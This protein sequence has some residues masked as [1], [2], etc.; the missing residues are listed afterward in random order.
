MGLRA[1]EATMKKSLRSSLACRSRL[2]KRSRETRWGTMLLELVIAI[3]VAA[4]ILGTSIGIIH[5]MLTA[6][7]NS[8]HHEYRLMTVNRLARS[9]RAD[10]HAARSADVAVENPQS[11]PRLTLALPDGKKIVYTQEK[12][13]IERIETS[14]DGKAQHERFRLPVNSVCRFEVLSEPAGVQ[15]VVATPRGS[16]AKDEP[17]DVVEVEAVTGR[18]HRFAGAAP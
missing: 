8:T 7:R 10:V 12:Q 18:D 6:E 9:V 2:T 3:S 16:R 5:L 13:T 14:A 15:M 1:R 4:V 11:M 17:L